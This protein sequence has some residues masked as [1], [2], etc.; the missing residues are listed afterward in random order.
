M[1]KL[2]IKQGHVITAS[3]GSQLSK[4]VCSDCGAVL[5]LSAVDSYC[6]I[7]CFQLPEVEHSNKTDV[8]A[9]LSKDKAI[10][11]CSACDSIIKTDYSKDLTDVLVMSICCTACGSEDVEEYLDSERTIPD[12]M[13]DKE[14]ENDQ[15]LD[16]KIDDGEVI[17]APKPIVVGEED[18]EEESNNIEDK[19]EKNLEEDA[20]K[21]SDELTSCDE[22]AEMD[23]IFFKE[24]EPAW[25]LFSGID[26]IIRIRLSKQPSSSE[27][28]FGTESYINIFKERVKVSSLA[29]AIQEFN[30]EIIKPDKVMSA[31]EA[32]NV[33]YEKLQATVLPKF[34]DCLH[35][36]ISGM[37]RNIY[38]DL[39]LKLKA[40]FFDELS[41]QGVQDA[42]RV[43]EASFEVAGAEVFEALVARAMEIFNKPDANRE[44]IKATIL[45]TSIVRS[46]IVPTP[47]TLEKLET[48][49]KLVS[50]NLSVV[51]SIS[52]PLVTSRFAKESMK[53]AAITDVRDRISLRSRR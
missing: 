25:V 39:N 50:G 40:A 37:T 47:D 16:K 49:S 52:D 18:K 1:R 26:P 24:P 4:T 14:E 13:K 10:L 51:D 12:T 27:P 34:I 35:I 42:A 33:V 22:I 38:P 45:G 5:M 28:L 9:S 30:A 20:D 48:I 31:M 44:E 17:D 15:I 36:A 2:E 11:K 23:A 46:S 43:V 29:M 3:D 6:P 19:E 7:C 8:K 41:A 53:S 32:Q 21:V